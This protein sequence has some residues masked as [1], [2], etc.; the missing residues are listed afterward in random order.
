MRGFKKMVRNWSPGLVGDLLF[1]FYNRNLYRTRHGGEYDRWRKYFESHTHSSLAVL[2]AEQLRRLRLFLD[3]ARK[4]VH[5]RSVLDNIDIASFSVEDVSSLPLLEKAE[6]LS[7]L[8]EIA[9]IEQS[10]GIVSMTGGT[11]GNSMK[12]LYDPEDVQ[13]RFAFVD[14][15]RS[16]HGYDLGRKIAWSTGKEILSKADLRMGRFFKSDIIN[17]IRFFSTFHLNELTF[18]KYWK[19]LCD[20][21]PEYLLGFPS[22]YYDLSLYA[23]ANGLKLEGVKCF[24]PTAETVTSQHREAIGDV[25]G[26]AVVDQ[27]ASS[28]G[29]PFIVQCAEGSYHIQPHTGVFEVVDENL[30]ACDSGE[31]LV[32]AFSTR[33]T[34]LIRYRV[35]DSVT[36]DTSGRVCGCG[37]GGPLVLSIDGRKA[38]VIV[39]PGGARISSVNFSN[40]VKEAKGVQLFQ[41]HQSDLSAIEVLVVCDATFD[42]SQEEF[43][44]QNIRERVGHEMAV[45]LQRVP[46]IPRERS[47]KFRVIKSTLAR[48]S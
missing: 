27:Y 7:G 21:G 3:H 4:S 14:A 5:Y 1:S 16:Y 20:F 38:D 44:V 8:S 19:A 36:M 25:F 2:Q 41:V 9:T 46:S 17:N 28:E 45:N 42:P 11:T 35:G 32:T 39:T 13:E 12:V 24:F 47:G 37:F 43:L 31:L 40:A 34:P 23:R 6:I 48:G 18:P 15:F 30:E 33:G 22:F 26:C 10:S 29:A